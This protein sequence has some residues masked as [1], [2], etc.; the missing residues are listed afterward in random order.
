[1]ADDL[2]EQLSE[3]L[4][5]YAFEVAETVNEI[6]ESKAAE[7]KKEISENTP[8][9]QGTQKKSWRVSL[10]KLDGIDVQATV[11]SKDYRK[12]HLLEHGHLLR[13]GT[14]RRGRK[15]TTAYEY[16]GKSTDT[17]LA[18]YPQEIAKAIKAVK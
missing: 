7:L 2:S 10:D 18:D 16:V 8:V 5:D 12:V 11:Y 3:I 9:G 17:V 14:T 15:K 13:D 4:E 1:M 6:T